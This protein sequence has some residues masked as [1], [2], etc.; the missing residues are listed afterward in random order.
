MTWFY[1]LVAAGFGLILGSFFNVCIY[2]IP[3]GMTLGDRS[4]CP[5]C[6]AGVKWYDNVPLASFVA[7]RGKCRSCKGRISWRY[8]LVEAL[9]G[10]LFASTYWWSINVVPD[11]LGVEGG[12]FVPELLIGLLFISILLI[13]AFIDYD[14]GIIPNV[15]IIPGAAA[16]FFLVVGVSIY[17]EDPI[18]I[19]QAA[20]TGILF[21]VFLF[22]IGLIVGTAVL[23]GAEQEEADSKEDVGPFRYS[24]KHCKDDDNGEEEEDELP[25]ALGFGDLKLALFMGLALGYF[26]WFFILVAVI[27]GCVLS[28]IIAIIYQ[29]PG[30]KKITFGPFL[31]VGS[32]VAL[33]WGPYFYQL[34]FHY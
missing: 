20:A 24:E 30:R 28:L 16:M 22:L 14:H 26:N 34:L 13:V 11:Y 18:R 27:T 3:I 9:S 19:A 15:V 12:P 6:G 10:A 1:Y 21:A 4:I 17:R 5:H 23:K 7:L 33:Y 29:I 32:I 8:P 25:L 2:R 31:A